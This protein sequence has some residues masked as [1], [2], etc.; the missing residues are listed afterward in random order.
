[1]SFF[2]P[3]D[4]YT[5][6]GRDIDGARWDRAAFG[7]SDLMV[8]EGLA[9]FYTEVV[10]E[11]MSA[12]APGLRIAFEKLLDLQSDPYLAYRQWMQEDSAKRDETVR[13]TMVAART[14]GA[15]KN[16]EWMRLLGET[17]I[18]LRRS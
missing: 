18:S 13:F 7:N 10:T 4:G 6:L 16:G 2:E 5:H 15:I 11:R 14:R 17:A 12:R 1:M 8:T 9:Q 3:E